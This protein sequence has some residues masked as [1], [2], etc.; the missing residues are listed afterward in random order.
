MTR[1]TSPPHRDHTFLDAMRTQGDPP[2][3]DIVAQV[4]AEGGPDALRGL[5]RRLFEHGGGDRA[6]PPAVRELG[7]PAAEELPELGQV[8]LCEAE[9]LYRRYRPEVRIVLGGYSLPAAYAARKGVQVLHRTAHLLK[10]PAR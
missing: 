4:V 2:A 5:M 3:D 8:R 9:R 10:A 1:S 7:G 6:L